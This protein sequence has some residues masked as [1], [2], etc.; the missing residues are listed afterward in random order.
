MGEL[1]FGLFIFALIFGAIYFGIQSG[2]RTVAVREYSI[3]ECNNRGL[4]WSLAE[5]A[6]TDSSNTAR[7]SGL[8]EGIRILQDKA[9]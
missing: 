3:E 8:K 1:M 6:I 4:Q 2:K 7:V 9:S 5:L